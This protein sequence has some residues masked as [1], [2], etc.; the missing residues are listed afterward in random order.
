MFLILIGLVLALLGY[1]TYHRPT[2][3]LTVLV[4][5]LPSYGIRFSVLGVPATLL[6]AAIWV[7]AAA[8]FARQWKDHGRPSWPDFNN[9]HQTGNPFRPYLW[10]IKLWLLVASVAVI[11]SPNL[12]GALGIWKAYFIEPL[13]VFALLVL[14]FRGRQEKWWLLYALGLTS[15]AM[16]A[17]AWYQ[18]FTG[19]LLPIP[20]ST[21]LPRRVTAWYSYPNAVGLYLAPVLAGYITWMLQ[22]KDWSS[23]VWKLLVVILG[24]GAIIFSITQGA[25]I[26]VAAGTFVG[27]LLTYPKYW[28]QIFVVGIVGGSLAIAFVQSVQDEVF[29]RSA[30]GRV[31]LTVWQE[32]WAMLKD[33]PIEG[34]GLAGYQQALVPYHLDWR[35]DISPYKLEIFLYPH[36]VFLNFWTELGLGGLIVFIWLLV[37]FFK[38]AWQKRAEPLTQIA[39]AA[40]MALLV[41]GL[42]DAP[43]F[44]NDLAVLFWILISLSLL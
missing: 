32:T 5:M 37:V 42:V 44:K 26:G 43:Y 10:I 25:W 29:F 41:H 19:T 30:S 9:A 4:A 11:V 18:H 7:C 40:M 12:D 14:T 21:N 33:H 35:K 27:L 22:K 6:E 1:L 3:G 38:I 16:G 28:K 15:L 8:W 20:W 36:N 13:M 39:I 23:I 31:R 34:A 17:L 24:L 2:W